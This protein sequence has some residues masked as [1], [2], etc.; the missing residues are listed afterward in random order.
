MYIDSF[1]PQFLK[2]CH[3]LL[4]SVMMNVHPA[5]SLL[6]FLRGAAYRG[7]TP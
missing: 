7:H 2:Q 1:N 4:G 3:I 6:S 5:P